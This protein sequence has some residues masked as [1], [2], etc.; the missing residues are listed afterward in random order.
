MISQQS[1][2]NPNPV[3]KLLNLVVQQDDPTVFVMV[4]DEY[5]NVREVNVH[6][7][8]EIAGMLKLHNL[9]PP[10]MEKNQP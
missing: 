10:K 1:N 3:Q 2:Q 9:Q 5:D 7:L 4:V 6:S 8:D